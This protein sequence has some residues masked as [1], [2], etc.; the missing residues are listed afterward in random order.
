MIEMAGT[1]L[2]TVGVHFHRV[3]FHHSEQWGWLVVRR[4]LNGALYP[5]ELVLDS[6][7]LS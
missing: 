1:E 7:G 3:V 5:A 4:V 6:A 2:W